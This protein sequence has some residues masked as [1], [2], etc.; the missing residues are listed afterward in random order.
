MLKKSRM[1]GLC[2][3]CFERVCACFCVSHIEKLSSDMRPRSKWILLGLLQFLKD[4]DRVIH[5]GK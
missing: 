2:L 1:T 4:A 5:L 3:L